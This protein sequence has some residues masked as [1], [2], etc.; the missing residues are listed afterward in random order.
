MTLNSWSSCFYL[1]SA[2]VILWFLFKLCKSFTP[3]FQDY[4]HAAPS[5]RQ[6]FSW[7]HSV[8][9]SLLFMIHSLCVYLRSLVN[10]GLL[11]FPPW[12][13]FLNCVFL[14]MVPL[15]EIYACNLFVNSI[16]LIYMPTFMLLLKCQT[17]SLDFENIR[18]CKSY[19]S[20]ILF[21]F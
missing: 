14:I 2:R 15:S 20:F 4:R 16:T 6:G 19:K 1:P 10:P 13:F 12:I 7:Y 5:P 3:K 18:L 11:R 9:W 21:S 17:L 8:Y